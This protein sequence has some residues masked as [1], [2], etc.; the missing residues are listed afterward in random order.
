[1]GCA[2]GAE[3]G[4]GQKFLPRRNRIPRQV[5]SFKGLAYRARTSHHSAAVG[6]IILGQVGHKAVENIEDLEM[7]SE[8]LGSEEVSYGP[9]AHQESCESLAA[10]AK[11]LIIRFDRTSE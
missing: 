11:F 2:I 4:T 7:C 10:M 8:S 9:C 1:M 3:K 6:R 5:A